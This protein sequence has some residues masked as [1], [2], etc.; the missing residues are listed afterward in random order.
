MGKPHSVGR[1]EV[2]EDLGFLKREWR[3][4]RI[5]WVGMGLLVVA[6]LLGAF[7]N[8]PLSKRQ[9]G[10]TAHFAVEYERL[11]RHGARAELTFQIAP[12]LQPDTIVQLILPLSYVRALQLEFTAPQPLQ[13]SMQGQDVMFGFRAAGADRPLEIVAQVRPLG[14]GNVRGRVAL[15]NAL[16]LTINH[17][18]LP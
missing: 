9:V 4:Q 13:Q 17:F 1:I 5:G 3:W 11:L 10:N 16:A 18:V 12:A 8:G 7:G 14:Y 15:P 2:E 6:G